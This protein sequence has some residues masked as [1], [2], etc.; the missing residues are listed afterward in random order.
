[1]LRK[2]PSYGPVQK[3]CTVRQLARSASAACTFC[4]SQLCIGTWYSLIPHSLS[5]RNLPYAVPA[6]G[7]HDAGDHL[8]LH[9]PLGGALAVLSLGMLQYEAAYRDAGEWDT[10]A[11]TLARA[12]QYLL[13]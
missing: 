10:A 1:V 2:T 6:G 7:L 9:L 5:L 12:G 11:R 13:E 4:I 8:K 3:A